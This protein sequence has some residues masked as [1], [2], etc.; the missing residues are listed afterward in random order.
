M[1]MPLL[2]TA[3]ALFLLTGY[4]AYAIHETKPAETP[5]VM[6]GAD[7]GKLYEYIIKLKPYN[8]WELWPGKGKQY[9]GTEPHGALLTTYINDTAYDSVKKKK[10]MTDGAIIVKENYT[11]DKKFVALSV[12]YK[13]KGYNPEAG[14]WFWAR[15]SPDGK[16]EASGKARGCI[17][18]H[19]K[20]KD[21]DYIF[22]GGLKK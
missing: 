14:D 22:T 11:A 16:V 3:I 7:A 19:E 5:V 15:Y 4:Q 6:P 18:C 1:K 10:F 17:G 20:N 13:V 2:V 12:M 9:K 8:A 21:N